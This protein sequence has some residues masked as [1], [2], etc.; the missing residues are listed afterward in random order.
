MGEGF[1]VRIVYTEPEFQRRNPGTPQQF[2]AEFDCPRAVTPEQAIEQAL[3]R[4]RWFA[5]QSGVG[6]RRVIESVQVTGARS[7][8]VRAPAP[9][10]APSVSGYL[11]PTSSEGRS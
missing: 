6:W 2:V 4:W 7:G 3:V 10:P 1:S 5:A 9:A 11:P 8:A